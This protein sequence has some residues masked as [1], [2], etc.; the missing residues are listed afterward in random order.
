MVY[1]ID[2]DPLVAEVLGTALRVKTD[3]VVHTFNVPAQALA[4]AAADV[5]ISDFKMPGIDGSSSFEHVREQ[6]PDAVS[7]FLAAAAGQGRAA[8]RRARGAWGASA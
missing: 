1:V 5:V 2:A 4:T 8:V 7:L 6:V 3:S